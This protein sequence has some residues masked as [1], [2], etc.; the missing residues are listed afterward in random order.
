VHIWLRAPC[1]VQIKDVSLRAEL[2]K[3]KAAAPALDDL[4]DVVPDEELPLLDRRHIDESRLTPEQRQWREHG[5]LI[6]P[7]LMPD[8][9]IDAYC[10]VREKIDD[11]GGYP[12]VNPYHEVEEMRDLCLFPP[13]TRMVDL[14]IGEPMGL[15]LALTGWIST[16]RNWHQDDYLNPPTVT[17][18]YA[19]VW[20][21]LDQIHP[22]A[23]PFEYIA[24]SHRWPIVRREKLFDYLD[25][26]ERTKLSWPKTSEEI[27]VPLLER[28]IEESGCVTQRFVANKGDVLIWHAHLVHRGSRPRNSKLLRKALIA[29]FTSIYRLVDAPQIL[30]HKGQ[31]YYF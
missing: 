23:G 8:H 13:L 6:L 12:S 15:S 11:P 10:R 2:R 22:D 4:V 17:G 27:L 29:H 26:E 16:E 28:K 1:V 3:K 9:L 25:P 7:R 18:W 5:F 24:G 20:I 21:A 30:R 31:G 19:A 14:L